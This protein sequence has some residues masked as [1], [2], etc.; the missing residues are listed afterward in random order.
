VG[1]VGGRTWRREWERARWGGRESTLVVLDGLAVP[2][3]SGAPS[4]TRK[5]KGV[6]LGGAQKRS[7]RPRRT[8]NSIRLF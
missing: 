8:P 3:K 7:Y 2:T 4:C 1:V 6:E 5:E